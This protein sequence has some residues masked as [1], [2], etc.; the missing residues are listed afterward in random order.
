[1][2]IHQRLA[3]LGAAVPEILL[4]G[5]GTDLEK[6]AI[7]ACDQ[8]TQDRSY[9]EQVEKTAGN[10][11]ALRLIFPEIYLEEPDRAERIRAIRQTMDSYLGGVFAPPRRGCVY[12]E[13]STPYHPRRRGLVM[14]VDL[15]Q[16]DW[17]AASRLLVRSTEE[18]LPERLI[19]RTDIRRGAKLEI[20][21][22][23]L[24]ID[25]ERDILL[26]A[27]GERAKKGAAAYETPLMMGS[28]SLKGW[29]LDSPADWAVLAGGLEK[30]AETSK[31]RYT[32][33]PAPP[34]LYAAGDGNHS[35][36]AAKAVWEEYKKDHPGEAGLEQHP[37]RWALVEVENLYDPGL[38]FEPI[39]RVIFGADPGAVL[40]CLSSLPDFSSRSIR[41]RAELSALVGDTRAEGNRFGFI[42]GTNLILIES[43]APELA[44][45][46]LQPLLDAFIA[47]SANAAV[48]TAVSIDYI[49]GEEELFRLAGTQVPERPAAGILLPPVKKSGLFKT[50]A[51]GGPLPRKSFSMGEAEEKRFYMEC[52]VLFP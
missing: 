48:N 15:E 13:R 40:D 12:I 11:S 28:G 17:K 45:K 1:M 9:W 20:P 4:P 46:S 51:A 26:P 3:A 24:L 22:I 23:L 47:G 50:A 29:F 41:D 19:P 33:S 39:H 44:T 18:T 49:H 35:L 42:A 21:H 10:T 16:Y 30:L 6:W 14:A 7:I 38:S 5:P 34:F 43:G 31:T 25:D 37:A 27:L 2:D 52:R 36:A 32:P 8:F